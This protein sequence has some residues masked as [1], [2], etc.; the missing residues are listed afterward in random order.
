MGRPNPERGGQ[1]MADLV[2]VLTVICPQDNLDT[3]IEKGME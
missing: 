1:A 3:T 2:E